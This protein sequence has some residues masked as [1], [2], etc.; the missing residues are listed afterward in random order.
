MFKAVLSLLWTYGE[1]YFN[2]LLKENEKVIFLES[3]AIL[4][5]ANESCSGHGLT[6]ENP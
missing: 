1:V 2:N 4:E 6:V 3:F 5:T